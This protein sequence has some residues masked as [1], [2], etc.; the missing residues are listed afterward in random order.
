MTLKAQLARVLGIPLTPEPK[1][2]GVK[3][4]IAG[5][6]LHGF[7]EV[8]GKGMYAREDDV[9]E[10]HRNG[11]GFR[12]YKCRHCRHWHSTSLFRSLNSGEE[13]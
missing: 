7:C 5:T 3:V 13:L 12:A 9:P 8:S 6:T 4:E 1:V 10:T 11:S 2:S